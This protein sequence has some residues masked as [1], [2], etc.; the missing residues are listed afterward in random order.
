MNKKRLHHFWTK[1]RGVKPWYFLVLF[2]ISLGVCV[3]ALRQ[4]NLTMVRLRNDV[5]AADKNGVDVQSALKDLQAYVITHMNTN[6]ASGPNPVY[7]P[8]QLVYSYERLQQAADQSN[9]NAQLYTNAEDYCQQQIPNGYSGSYRISC[10]EQYVASHGAAVI[11]IPASLYE[12]SFISPS[13]S[14]DLAG[15][16]LLATVA[17]ALLFI[18]S[19]LTRLWL[20]HAST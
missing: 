2:V 10:I 20:K 1:F 7:P 3:Y 4:N 19:W 14:P 8:I 6:L 13:W 12:F 9:S 18:F 15:W 17:L 16:A 5:Y 11:T